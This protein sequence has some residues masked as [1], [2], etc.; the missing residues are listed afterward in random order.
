MPSI[1]GTMN[2]AKM[3]L[4]THQLSLEVTGQNISNVNNPN[5]TRQ[6]VQLEAAFPIK[7]GGSPGLIGTGV[8]RFSHPA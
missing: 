8:R 2:T 3:A 7:P 6:E 5:F 4:I 1:Y